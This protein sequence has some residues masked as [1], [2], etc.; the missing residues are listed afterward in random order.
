MTM[1]KRILIVLII[2]GMSFLAAQE[3]MV[4]QD[5]SFDPLNLHEPSLPF[6]DGSMIYEIITDIKE[7]GERLSRDT[8]RVIE[9]TGWKVQ[10][11]S[12]TD[13]Y[14]ADTV[15]FQ[16]CD[17]FIEE[18]V[19]KV[20]NSPNYKIRVGNCTTRE[21]AEE[22]LSRALDLKYRDAWIIRTSV[23]VEERLIF[24]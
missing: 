24:Y 19:V 10:L 2:S 22:L 4:D 7:P 11:F 14:K 13:F 18:E 21:S 9:K 23:K 17:D 16:A 6:L 8:V 12:T 1:N 5:E 3:W 15:Y 20:F